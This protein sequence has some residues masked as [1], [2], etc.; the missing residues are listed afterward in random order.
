[1]SA[2]ELRGRLVRRAKRAEL[3]LTP[4]LADALQA[5]YE[6]LAR[7]N[8]KINLTS[9]KLEEMSD[10]AL[11]RLLVEPLI[12]ARHIPV[13][14]RTAIDFGSGGGSPAIPI[15]LARP[16]LRL[17]MVEAKVRKC[18][19][20]REAIRALNL[21]DTSVETARFEDL[22][23]RPELHES[24]DLGIMRAVRVE[25]QVLR[26]VQAFLRFGGELFLFRGPS[27][28]LPDP[29]APLQWRHTVPL[30]EPGR[31]RLIILE[32]TAVPA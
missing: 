23:P 15:K 26:T 18:A 16:E 21:P 1:M 32:K 8:Q 2:R 9:F 14:N 3:E 13:G 4:E 24:F 11:D 17:V 12:A 31:G 20:L 19:F 25:G 7:W 10:E 6:L 5:Y 30:T 22:L 28:Q 29:L 27:G